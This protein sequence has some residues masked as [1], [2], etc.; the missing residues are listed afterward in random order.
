MKNKTCHFSFFLEYCSFNFFVIDQT[1]F[2]LI[3]IKNLH[4]GYNFL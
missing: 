1:E 3:L 2:L 4:N